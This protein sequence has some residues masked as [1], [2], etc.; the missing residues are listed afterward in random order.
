MGLCSHFILSIFGSSY[1]TLAAGPLWLLIVGYIPG[2]P[3]ML[4]ITVARAE[5]RFNQAA[6]FLTA[7]AA[8]RMI[9]LVVGGKIGD[10]YGLSYAMLAVAVVQA[11]LTTPSVL[12][13][14]FG[15]VTVRS[16][17]DSATIDEAHSTSSELAE[18]MRLRQEAGIA[19]L[20]ELATRVAPPRP[21]SGALS[22]DLR[23]LP[24][25]RRTVRSQGNYRR[26][27]AVSETRVNPVVTETNWWPDLNEETFRSR[28]EMG[29]AALLSIATHSVRF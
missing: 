12:R 7:F 24:Q 28:Q 17:A 10:L 26:L 19:A 5:G 25:A 6:I 1:A 9:A 27:T 23:P 8:F 13:T 22:T 18:E 15:S 16:A 11:L 21:N 20:I 29:M 14:A 2:I 4:Y 3:N